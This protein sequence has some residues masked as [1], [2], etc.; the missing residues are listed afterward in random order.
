MFF[1]SSKVVLPESNRKVRRTERGDVCSHQKSKK[2]H[3]SSPS[4]S[5]FRGMNWLLKTSRMK[6]IR[7]PGNDNFDHIPPLKTGKNRQKIII[8]SSWCR[9]L[10]SAVLGGNP[11]SRVNVNLGGLPSLKL[12]AKAPE[13]G[14]SQKETIAFQPSIFGCYVSFREGMFFKIFKMLGAWC[15]RF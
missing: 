12:T 5:S 15:G 11:K 9:E 3:R 1:V 8:H 14:P 4:E 6:A 10:F 2:I 7:S 13:N